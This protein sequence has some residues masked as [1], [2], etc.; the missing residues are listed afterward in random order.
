MPTAS[1]SGPRLALDKYDVGCA[2]CLPRN[3]L[4]PIVRIFRQ[5]NGSSA[6]RTCPT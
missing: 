3:A 1:A 2:C 5:D 6:G 4:D